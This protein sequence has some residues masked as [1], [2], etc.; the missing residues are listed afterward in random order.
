MNKSV[1][2]HAGW[3]PVLMMNKSVDTYELEHTVEDE[4]VSPQK[5]GL[6]PSVEDE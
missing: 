3:N 4:S 2:K 6:E 1:L 5:W